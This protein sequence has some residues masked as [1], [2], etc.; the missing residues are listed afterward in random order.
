[1]SILFYKEKKWREMDEA[2]AANRIEVNLPQEQ[3]DFINDAHQKE[4]QY[5]KNITLE[6][7]SENE[8]KE[9]TDLAPLRVFLVRKAV[10]KKYATNVKVNE[11][12]LHLKKQ[13]QPHNE[14]PGA[15]IEDIPSQEGWSF[16]EIAIYLKTF[17]KSIKQ[18]KNMSLKNKAFMGGCIS[19]AA[20]AFRHD[21]NILGE[22]L[23]SQFE[24]WMYREC[25]IKKQTI[26]KL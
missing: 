25:G 2:R 20:R 3:I 13:Y 9:L 16:D 19:T 18:I 11:L 23:P 14:E 6:S 24:D 5:W 12:I 17:S 15:F 26:I 8:R 1:M 22:N 10:V 7:K 4:W 21:E